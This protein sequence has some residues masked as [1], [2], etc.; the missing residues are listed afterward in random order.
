MADWDRLARRLADQA[1]PP[2]GRRFTMSDEMRRR[3][4]EQGI[5]ASVLA[6]LLMQQDDSP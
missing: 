6:P 1:T 4:I 3:I 5:P 2:P